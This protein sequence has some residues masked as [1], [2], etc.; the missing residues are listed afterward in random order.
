MKARV[1]H[2]RAL[3]LYGCKRNEVLNPAEIKQYGLDSFADTGANG[4]NKRSKTDGQAVA[5][6]SSCCTFCCTF[7]CQTRPKR[8][9]TM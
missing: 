9:K 2:D 1:V 6:N 8:S 3:L 7:C 4:W 5:Q